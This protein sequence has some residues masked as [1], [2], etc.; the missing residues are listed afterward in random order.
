[1]VNNP[2]QPILLAQDGMIRFKKNEIVSYLLDNGGITLNDLIFHDFT[3]DD[4]MQFAQLIGY[5]I[6]GYGELSYV[7]N[8]SYNKANREAD[9]I[10]KT[11]KGD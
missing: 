11:L 4:R 8:K 2:M 9:K 10:R 1:M 5:S 7:S 6:G 3:E